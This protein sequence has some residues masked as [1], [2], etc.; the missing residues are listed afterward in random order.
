MLRVPHIS[1]HSAHF[2]PNRCRVRFELRVGRFTLKNNHNRKSINLGESAMKY[3]F[4][5]L[6]AVS[7]LVVTGSALAH[8]SNAHFDQAEPLQLQGTVVEYHLVNPHS[9]IYLDVT[10]VNGEI[11]EWALETGGGVGRLIRSNWSADSMQPGDIITATVA[12]LRDGTPGG[13]LVD[14]TL[15]DGT[16]LGAGE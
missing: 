8:H 12:P 14:V 4:I 13:L 2:G 5:G 7:A 6:A 15:P 1:I 16:V 9:Y 11:S 3:G 10:E